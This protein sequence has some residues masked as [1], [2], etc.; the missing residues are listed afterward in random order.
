[1]EQKFKNP[2]KMIFVF[3]S[4]M[5]GIHGAGAAKYAR[6]HKQAKLGVGE[7]LTGQAYALPTKDHKIQ[8]ISVAEIHE[9]VIRFQDFARANPDMEFQVTRVGCGLGG[10]QD[11][12]IAIMFLD[13]PD[14]CYFD[15]VWQPYFEKLSQKMNYWGTF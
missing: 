8:C 1:M 13:S 3:G 10:H 4:N 12:R 2:D 5:A 11:S 14:N 9:A 15:T 7:G 6:F